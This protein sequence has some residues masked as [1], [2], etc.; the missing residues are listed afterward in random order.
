MSKCF[1]YMNNY[2]TTNSITNSILSFCYNATLI[3]VAI[4]GSFRPFVLKGMYGVI[5]SDVCACVAYAQALSY[6][7]R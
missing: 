1:N 6:H 3:A 7:N 5:V 4:G 2:R